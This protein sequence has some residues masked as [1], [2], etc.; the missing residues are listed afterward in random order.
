MGLFVGCVDLSRGMRLRGVG[1]V[2]LNSALCYN[3]NL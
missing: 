3:E 1:I 2:G